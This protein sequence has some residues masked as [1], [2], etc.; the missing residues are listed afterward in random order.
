MRA[1]LFGAVLLLSV[2][3]AEA[4]QASRKRPVRRGQAAAQRARD[5]V[6]MRAALRE[7]GL[8]VLRYRR[9]Q[10]TEDW[11]VS[12]YDVRGPGQIVICFNS[13]QR[14]WSANT[15][16][17]TVDLWLSEWTGAWQ[18]AGG[19]LKRCAIFT[20]CDDGLPFPE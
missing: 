7:F 1:I 4:R 5:Q 3:G 8:Q 10:D 2:N 15:Q 20:C 16:R 12:T 6:T 13:N 18:N 9:S 11:D 14:R 17:K 19:D